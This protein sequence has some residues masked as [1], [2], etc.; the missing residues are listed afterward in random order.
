MTLP[1]QTASGS[2]WT[3]GDLKHFTGFDCIIDVRS[4][5]EYA[6][7]HVPGAVNYPVL[8]NAE[9]AQI[10]TLHKQASAFDAKRLGAALV[11]ANIGRHLREPFFQ[12][13]PIAWQPLI[14]CWR[15][16]KRS[17]A[18]THVLRQIG[19]KAAQL[20]GGYR[21]YRRAVVAAFEEANLAAL[22]LRFI[23]IAGRTGSGKSLLLQRLAL[24]GA[25]T[26]DLEQL[27]GHRGSVLGAVPGQAQ[28][29]QK[30]FESRLLAALTGFESSRPVFVESES[31]KVGQLRVPDALMAR[32]RA[33]ECV[34]LQLDLEQRVA[35][36]GQEYPHFVS[37][38]ADL[39]QQ[40][41]HLKSLHGDKCLA[42]WREWSARGEWKTLVA[43]LLT[44]HYDPSYDKSMLRNFPR[45]ES[46][47][48]I[49]LANGDLAHFD[50]TAAELI[51]AYG[52]NAK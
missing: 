1:S 22:H 24:A 23:V 45:L 38:P 41:T 7:D 52:E 3:L 9:R 12:S 32:I 16:G 26:L 19:W 15:G 31:K 48:Y 29:S 11:A 30:Q 20:D 10:G 27:A 21:A 6:E 25:Q 39:V 33:S 13:Q 2:L 35:L 17:G 18:L 8:D 40:L 46:A 4:P 47:R 51:E 36:L 49:T 37:E 50:K 28:P 14:Y 42:Q 44:N 43:A 34:N 5:A